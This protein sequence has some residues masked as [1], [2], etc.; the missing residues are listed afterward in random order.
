MQHD[1]DADREQSKQ[2]LRDAIDAMMAQ[3]PELGAIIMIHFLDKM[4]RSGATPKYDA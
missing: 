4:R 3:D 2:K 1:D